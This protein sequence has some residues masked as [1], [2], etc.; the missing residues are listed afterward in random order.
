MAMTGTLIVGTIC[1]VGQALAAQEAE[2]RGWVG[3]LRWR[4]TFDHG[5]PFPFTSEHTVIEVTWTTNGTLVHPENYDPD[6]PFLAQHGTYEV[7]Q[8]SLGEDSC[9]PDRV[10]RVPYTISGHGTGT[11]T[12][13]VNFVANDDPE[14][15]EITA[16]AAGAGTFPIVGSGGCGSVRD[17]DAG[18]PA[19]SVP[20]GLS[21]QDRPVDLSGRRQL[22]GRIVNEVDSNGD[23][24][25]YE[26]SWQLLR[27]AE[28]LADLAVM[29]TMTVPGQF[30]GDQVEFTI[31]VLNH[32]PS[33]AS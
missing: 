30:V 14:T 29:K 15:Y 3:T 1:V 22:E 9:I 19:I 24:F 16:T 23:R 11:G 26:A 21:R 18:V 12:V 5:A 33:A 28:P 17:G 6:S 13:T 25:T 27:G 8:H 31:E 20:Y 4:Q 2:P 7:T 10:D 32:G